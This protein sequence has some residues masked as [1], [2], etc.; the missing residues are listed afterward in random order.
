MPEWRYV[1]NNITFF[2]RNKKIIPNQEKSFTVCENNE[3][4][5]NK[6]DV[7]QENGLGAD[8]DHS[9]HIITQISFFIFLW[10][11]SYECCNSI[12]CFPTYEG[13]M[14]IVSQCNYYYNTM[15][16]ATIQNRGRFKR[17]IELQTSSRKWAGGRG[18]CNTHSCYNIPIFLNSF[19]EVFVTFLLRHS[20]ND[21]IDRR[22]FLVKGNLRYFVDI[23]FVAFNFEKH[24]LS[25]IFPQAK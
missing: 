25:I 8:F 11:F 2:F 14:Q 1:Q 3:S 23:R 21:E 20:K 17:N 12:L 7:L 6:T 16:I 5:N 24:D 22:S 19:G 15:Y 13:V 4:L 18:T 9:E 10:R